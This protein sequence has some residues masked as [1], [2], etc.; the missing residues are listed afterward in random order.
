[1]GRRDL[2]RGVTGLSVAGSLPGETGIRYVRGARQAEVAPSV[3]S[4]PWGDAVSPLGS[5]YD[6][7]LF[8]TYEYR[9]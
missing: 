2:S 9:L 6:T 1:M 8:S 3:V 7:G 5:V 4:I